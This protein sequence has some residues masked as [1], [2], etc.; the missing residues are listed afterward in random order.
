MNF[1]TACTVATAV[2]TVYVAAVRAPYTIH[3][4]GG[5]DDSAE[6]DAEKKVPT[7]KTSSV[8]R[9]L[10]GPLAHS[11]RRRLCPRL[12]VC[13][14][15]RSHRQRDA[16]LP[17]LFF[18]LDGV[19]PAVVV[20]RLLNDF[21]SYAEWFCFFFGRSVIAST[22]GLFTLFVPVS[23]WVLRRTG[24]VGGGRRPGG[25]A[26]ANM[27]A[28]LAL[29]VAAAWFWTGHWM[30]NNVLGVSLVVL[31]VAMG[32]LPS[33]KVAAIL[34]GG[35]LLYDI[36]WVFLSASFFG[37]NVMVAV[38][39]KESQHPAVWLA[40]T[41]SI[42]PPPSLV[43][44]IQLPGKLIF[45]SWDGRSRSILGLGDLAIPGMLVSMYHRAASGSGAKGLLY[46]YVALVAYAIGLEIAVVV[47]Y[48]FNTAQPA[49][50]YLV[51]AVTL[52]VMVIKTKIMS[53]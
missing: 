18:Q 49:L 23:T 30:L 7:D 50:L 12:A 19:G 21:L 34:L 10:K 8:P 6:P 52:P 53:H 37:E 45:P 48:T 20:R 44:T 33:L 36:F 27:A 43:R 4:L 1:D 41:L 15:R 28:C 32:R 17:L 51:P 11:E 3:T 26:S 16:R 47:S 22:Y 39:S 35:L 25:P 14:G 46:F 24:G 29:L 40:D 9:S 38:A 31:F 5:G 13:R 42:T 2:A